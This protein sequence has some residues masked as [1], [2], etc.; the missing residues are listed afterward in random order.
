MISIPKSS[1]L[2]YNL[3]GGNTAG[4]WKGKKMETPLLGQYIILMIIE[5]LEYLST[6]I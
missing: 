4:G 6:G 5:L 1:P 2:K 3:Y